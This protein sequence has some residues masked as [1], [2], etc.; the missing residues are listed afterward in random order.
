MSITK[1]SMSGP[2]SM[3]DNDPKPGW[4]LLAAL[5]VLFAA[6]FFYVIEKVRQ[7]RSWVSAR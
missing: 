2:L 4:F 1:D 3:S 7:F 6:A 5:T